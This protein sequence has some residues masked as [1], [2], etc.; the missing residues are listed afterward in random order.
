[1]DFPTREQGGGRPP[2]Y[3]AARRACLPYTSQ[4]ACERGGG[5]LASDAKRDFKDPAGFGGVSLREDRVCA[6][7]KQVLTL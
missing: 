4:A 5:A 1:M 3:A 6:F 7:W 2:D